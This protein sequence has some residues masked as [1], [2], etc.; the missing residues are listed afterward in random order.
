MIRWFRELW[1][2][3]AGCRRLLIS[4]A[5]RIGTGGKEWSDE[6]GI[7]HDSCLVLRIT[8]RVTAW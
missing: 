5:V 8:F 1:P 3:L 6:P 7:H 4:T 2:F